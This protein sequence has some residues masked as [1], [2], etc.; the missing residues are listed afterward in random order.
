MSRLCQI[1]LCLAAGTAVWLARAD[2]LPAVPARK[3]APAVVSM[4]PLPQSVSP[5][6]YFRG[7]LAMTPAERFDSLTNRSPEARQRIL[8]KVHEYLA[9]DP[10]ERELRLCATEL[11]WYLLPLLR[12]SPTNY[13]AQLALVPDDLRSLVKSRLRQWEILPPPLQREFLDN[14]RALHYFTR[15]EPTNSGGSGNLPDPQRQKIAEQFDQFFELTPA[16]KARALNTLSDAERAE[17]K[18]TLQTFDKLPPAQRFQCVRNFTKFAG[19]SSQER[20]EFLKNAQLWSRMSP[21]ERQTWRDLVAHVPLWPPLLHSAL[22][23]PMPPSPV[24]LPNKL[25]HATVA[26]NGN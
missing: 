26:T 9:L 16:E 22:M 24:R 4:P 5:V 1:L 6:S 10:D 18:K 13:D 19:M 8:A 25:R 15:V 23:P 2:N 7:L 20:A 21:Q 17:M 14:D 11:R 12:A 3:L